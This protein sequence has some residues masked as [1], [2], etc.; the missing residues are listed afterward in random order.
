MATLT[1]FT[2][3]DLLK[4]NETNLDV[5]T[6]N[7]ELEYY[8]QYLLKWPSLVF[9]TETPDSEVIGYMLGKSEGVN[10]D[11]HS[12]ISAVTVSK[13][14]RRLGI[15]KLLVDQLVVSSE[16]EEQNCYFMDLYVRTTNAVAVRMYK[17]MGFST[18]RRVVNYYASSDDAFD[19]RLPLRRDTKKTCLKR[20]KHTAEERMLTY[21]YKRLQ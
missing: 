7:Y 12:H 6:E 16:A 19:M 21:D 18:F 17:N 1:P 11:W 20:G 2:A 10:L 9:K 15:G 3:C 8:L 5:L 14:Y 13:N 4:I